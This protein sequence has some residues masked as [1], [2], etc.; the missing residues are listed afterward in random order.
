MQYLML[1]YSEESKDPQPC[2]SEGEAFMN[3]YWK[4]TEEVKEKKLMLG[5]NALQ[6]VSTATTVRLR[7]G[8]PVIADGPFAETKE[9][10]GG[11][12]L[13][14]CKDLDEAIEY[15]AKIPSAAHGSIEIR[16]IMVFE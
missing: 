5:S 9:Q 6:P 11:Y 15:A 2:S 14:D 10:L 12:Y 8:K 3:A 16:P 1:I 7:D 13:L 4:Y